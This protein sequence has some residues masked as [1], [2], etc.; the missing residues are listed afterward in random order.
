M[1]QISDGGNL[2]R[3][4]RVGFHIYKKL[5]GS[6]K[7]CRNFGAGVTLSKV[8]YTLEEAYAFLATQETYS[9]NTTDVVL[10]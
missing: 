7:V 4:R 10:S 6:Y 1:R 3:P 5:S 9:P 2:Y 8:C